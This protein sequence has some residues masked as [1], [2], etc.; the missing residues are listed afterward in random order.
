MTRLGV[1]LPSVNTVVEQW[2][3]RCM[4]VDA[5]LHTARILLPDALTPQ[6]VI[7]MDREGGQQAL[8]QLVSCRVAALVYGCFSSSVIGGL[9]YDKQ[10]QAELAATAAVPVSTA[11]A[12]M[13]DACS[14]LGLRRVCLVSPYGDDID[15]AE[16]QYLC[17]S[18]LRIVGHTHFGIVSS[19]AL[20][21]P[22][23]AKIA[24]A[25]LQCMSHEADGI[26]LTCMNMRSHL[27][28]E[29]LESQTG[30]PVVTCTQ[31]VLWKLMRMAGRTDVITGGG[32]LFMV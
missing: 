7:Q 5:S 18:G 17:A 1:I 16:R 13:I 8:R 32:R 23:G 31:A 27:A 21:E 30:K 2:Y 12:A 3:P 10:L 9:E 15:A 29:R 28:I 6:A 24:D 14:K 20:A 4:P 22:D 19:F 26:V 11:A 25:A